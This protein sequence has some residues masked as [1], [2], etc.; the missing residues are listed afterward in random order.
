M[1]YKE[2]DNLD[3]PSIYCSD[4]CEVSG[5]SVHLVDGELVVLAHCGCFMMTLEEYENDIF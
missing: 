4:C 5:G 3:D 2:G 1:K